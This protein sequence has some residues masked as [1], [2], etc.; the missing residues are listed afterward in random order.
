M[1]GE[2]FEAMKRVVR[3]LVII[4]AASIAI[5]YIFVALAT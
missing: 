4:A 3:W 2:F 5:A 1:G